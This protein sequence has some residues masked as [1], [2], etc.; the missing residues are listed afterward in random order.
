MPHVP[1]RLRE[2]QARLGPLV[3]EEAQLDLLCGF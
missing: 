3:V 2:R 1:G